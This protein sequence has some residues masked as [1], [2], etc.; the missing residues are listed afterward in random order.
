MSDVWWFVGALAVCGGI[1][2]ALRAVPFAALKPLRDSKTVQRLAVWMPAGILAILAV[3]TFS[4]FAVEPRTS[5][6]AAIALAVT[7]GVHLGFGRR[8]LLSVGLGTATFVVL[9]NLF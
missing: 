3:V 1:T 5:L 8:T 7:I 9:V 4:D 2:F 6:W